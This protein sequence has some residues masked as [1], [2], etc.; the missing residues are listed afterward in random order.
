M[1]FGE[2]IKELR[3]KKGLSKK[4]IAK[5]IGVSVVSYGRYEG[6]KSLPIKDSIYDAL[7]AVLGCTKEYLNGDIEKTVERPKK[8]TKKND[9]KKSEQSA[10]SNAINLTANPHPALSEMAAASNNPSPVSSNKLQTNGNVKKSKNT[11]GKQAEQPKTAAKNEPKP[12]NASI[13]TKVIADSST[14]RATKASGKKPSR[15]A[16][17]ATVAAELQYRE[18]SIS[19]DE[20]A[21]K[22]RKAVGKKAGKISLYVKPEEGKAYFVAGDINGSFDL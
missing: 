18:L 15:R 16:K 11:K 20:L 9:S 13:K 12:K 4:D 1:T 14:A 22:A 21:D 2:K 5:E 3:E 6:G 7:A 8:S 10:S 17:E 19:F